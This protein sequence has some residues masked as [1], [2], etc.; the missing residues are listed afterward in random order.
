MSQSYILLQTSDGTT[1]SKKFRVAS[2][3]D[4]DDGT[5]SR[6]QTINKTIGGGVDVAT[7]EVYRTWNP[8][9]MVCHTESD[10][11]YGTLSE[12][13][14]FYSYNN[15]NGV[16]SDR[17]TFVDHHGTSRTIVM[18]GDLRKQTLGV[19]IEGVNAWYYV[20]VQFQEVK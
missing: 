7:G 15:P 10:T 3:Q 1:L 8:V 11:T 19:A 14:T 6:S 2:G 17:I 16:P 5:L 18:L 13:E 20:K 12:L 4:Y 9:I